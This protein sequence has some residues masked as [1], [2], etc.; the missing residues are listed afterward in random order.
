MTGTTRTCASVVVIADDDDDP[1]GIMT[2][3]LYVSVCACALC[4]YVFVSVCTR[5]KYM[6]V[7]REGECACEGERER[8]RLPMSV[9]LSVIY[10]TDEHIF[11]CWKSAL[12][13]SF[14][15]LTNFATAYLRR[16]F[17]YKN[18]TFP[19]NKSHH[20]FLTQL[21]ACFKFA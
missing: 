17:Q 18:F 13:D 6:H 21:T 8:E 16:N 7:E 19:L 4:M 10:I 12:F 20:Q 14:Y 2:F 15:A 5:N 3:V 9:Y 11:L 1:T